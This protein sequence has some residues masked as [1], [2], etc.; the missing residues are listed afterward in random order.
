LDVQALSGRIGEALALDTPPIGLAFRDEAPSGVQEFD[1]NVPSSCTLWRRAEEGVFFAPA[2]RHFNCAVGAMTMG[3]ALPDRVQQ[4][5]M[6]AVGLMVGNEYISPDEPEHMP[7]LAGQPTGV[8]YGPLYALPVAPDVVLL[9]LT[10]RQAMLLEEAAGGTV[11]TAPAPAR[12]LGRPACAAI[13]DGRQRR[14]GQPVPGLHRHA[15][16]HRGGRR[17]PAGGSACPGARRGRHRA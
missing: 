11:W 15:H 7:S 13:P 10:P 4:D 16:L 17:S 3:F 5:L 9:W 2:E 1:G 14:R 12:V 8:L 6:D